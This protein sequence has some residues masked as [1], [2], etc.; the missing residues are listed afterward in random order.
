MRFL[1]RVT[2]PIE[3][4]NAMVRDPEFGAKMQAILEAVHTETAYFVADGGNRTAYVAVN[5]KESSEIPSV[6]EPFF[7]T[8]N[9][10]VEFLPAMTA[11]DLAR[12]GLDQL[13]KTY[14]ASYAKT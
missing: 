6:C 8:F 12:S 4:G 13:T 7:L 14:T 5:I 3:A 9:A 1:L 2:F 11:A 10:K